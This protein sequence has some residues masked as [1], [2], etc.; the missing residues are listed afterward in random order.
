[1]TLVY[2]TLIEAFSANF[3]KLQ[4]Y[5]VD[6]QMRIYCINDVHV[7]V[8]VNH[9]IRPLPPPHVCVG[10]ENG[11]QGDDWVISQDIVMSVVYFILCLTNKWSLSYNSSSV[12]KL[13]SQQPSVPTG[14]VTSQ[15]IVICGV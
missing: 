15:T 6:R 11:T 2:I 10:Q 9:W 13:C 12:F 7:Y 1:M 4:T 14:S 5:T 8:K 3:L